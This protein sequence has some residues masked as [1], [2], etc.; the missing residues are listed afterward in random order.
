VIAASLKSAVNEFVIAPVNAVT[1]TLPDGSTQQSIAGTNGTT[2]SS[3]VDL[4]SQAID[5]AKNLFSNR[6]FTVSAPLT[7][8][9]FQN[10]T[11]ANFSK[12]IVADVDTKITYLFQNGNLIDNFLSSDGKPADPTP[13]GEFHILDK[14][15]SQTMT[16]PGYVQPNVPWINY[17]DHSGDAIHGVYWRPASVFGHENMSHGCVGLPVAT[18]EF[19]YNWAPIGTT[20]ITSHN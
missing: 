6:G 16:G 7:T 12:L 11:P 9:A 20:V 8:L 4:D 5:I 1:I 18:A 13:I 19:V 14:L 2:L 3:S 15:T 10:D 17:F